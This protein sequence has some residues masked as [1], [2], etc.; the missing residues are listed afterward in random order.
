M[1][2]NAPGATAGRTV[3]VERLTLIV[4]AGLYLWCF[5]PDRPN[6]DGWIYIR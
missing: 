2:V 5:T 6:G 3:W 4:V 1:D